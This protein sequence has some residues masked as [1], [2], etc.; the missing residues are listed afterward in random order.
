M[1]YYNTTI[2]APDPPEVPCG[3]SRLRT[4]SMQCE[5]PRVNFAVSIGGSIPTASSSE[6][7]LTIAAMTR[8]ASWYAS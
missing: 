1:H 6:K 4:R 3:C 7:W 2:Q 5:G 8:V